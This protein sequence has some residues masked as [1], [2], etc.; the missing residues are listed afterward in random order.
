SKVIAFVRRGHPHA[1]LGA[2]VEYNLLGQHEAEIVLKKFAVG[3]D[4]DSKS[5]E[6][7]DAS[8]VYSARRITLR[9]LFECWREFGGSLIPFGLVGDPE[10]GAIR[11]PEPNGLA[12]AEIAVAPADIEA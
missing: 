3:F 11:I 7:I 10:F 4:V 8:H 12:R 1:C 5:V 2:V 9:L 6:M